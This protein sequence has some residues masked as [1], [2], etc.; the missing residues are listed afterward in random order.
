M[1]TVEG[2]PGE[3]T[4]F[5]LVLP[6]AEPPACAQSGYFPA[7]SG[8]GA[9]P[10]LAALSGEAGF[11]AA[12]SLGLGAAAGVSPAFAGVVAPDFFEA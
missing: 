9:L 8:F 5:A 7:V 6:P 11:A 3:R 2:R 1:V 12:D 4:V 10:A